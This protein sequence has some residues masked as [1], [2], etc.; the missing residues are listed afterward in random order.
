MVWL[1]KKRD[2]IKVSKFPFAVTAEFMSKLIA[3]RIWLS[4]VGYWCLLKLDVSSLIRSIFIDSIL[5]RYQGQHGAVT[6]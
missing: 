2:L 5:S 6:G 1:A 4:L 3:S